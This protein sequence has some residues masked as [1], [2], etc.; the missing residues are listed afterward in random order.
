MAYWLKQHKPKSKIIILDAKT[1]FS[2]QK[3]FEAGWAKHYGYGGAYSMI[4]WL[5]LADNRLIHLDPKT[6]TL[7]TDF[8]D[9][10]QGQVL[11]IIP[12]QQA[13][14][15]ARQSGLTDAGGWCPVEPQTSL[16]KFNPNIHVIGD[17]ANFA[18]IPKS[19]FAANSEAKNCAFAVVSLLNQR[20]PPEAHWLNT[21]YSLV[22]PQHGISVAGVYKLDD[23]Q[24]IAGVTGAG[25][26]SGSNIGDEPLLEAHYAKSVYRTLVQDSFESDTDID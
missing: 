19:A 13:G 18:P 15:I 26:V 12:P 16:S 6:R 22:T 14:A 23:H 11:N 7:E 1:G 17:A 25:G 9:K 21:C 4:E 20:P 24:K 3:L 10:F 5:S 2:K 8:G